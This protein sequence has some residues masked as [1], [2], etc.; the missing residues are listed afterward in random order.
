M[1]GGA[2]IRVIVTGP[3]K[4]TMIDRSAPLPEPVRRRRSSINLVALGTTGCLIVGLFYFRAERLGGVLLSV[5][6]GEAAASNLVFPDGAEIT[7]RSPMLDAVIQNTA[8]YSEGYAVGVP[9]T[10]DWC[11][12]SFRPPEHSG[13]PADFTA[14]SGWG[15]VYAETGKDY[16]LNPA[17]RIEIANSQTYVRIRSSRQ[18]VLTQDQ[19]VNPISGAYFVPD[20]SSM[21]TLPLQLEQKPDGSTAIGAL[22]PGRNAHFWIVARGSYPAGHADGVYVQMD[23]RVSDPKMNLVANA[24]A[25][26]WRDPTADFVQGFANNPT[27]GTSNWIKLSSGWSTLRFYSSSTPELMAAPPPPLLALRPHELAPTV[28]R[29]RASTSAPCL[30]SF[31]HPLPNE[32]LR[33]EQR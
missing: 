8:G 18:W 5:I 31:V 13:P 7:T 19:S 17:A 9:R 3:L 26:W 22:P 33:L 15:Q 4:A 28:I 20:F 12:G 16:Y 14:V 24:G 32:L 30:S 29:R 11:S 10:Y 23:L 27:A 1:E 25:D 2:G 21:D 6:A